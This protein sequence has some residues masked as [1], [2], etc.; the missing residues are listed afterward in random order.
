[1][2]LLWAVLGS[3]ALEGP[4]IEWVAYHRRHHRLRCRGDCGWSSFWF[5]CGHCGQPVDRYSTRT[6]DR[7]GD[8]G[9][10]R[11]AMATLLIAGGR[12]RF[13]AAELFE[14]ARFVPGAILAVQPRRDT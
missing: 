11:L 10:R 4:V 14:D 8:R 2:R 5:G 13:F 12:D 3:M 6:G 7:F 9:S 1:M